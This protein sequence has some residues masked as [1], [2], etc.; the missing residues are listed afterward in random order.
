MSINGSGPLPSEGSKL[1]VMKQKLEYYKQIIDSRLDS[2]VPEA[3][4]LEESMRYS[5]LAG[6]KRI[7][8]VLTLEFARLCGGRVEDALDAACAVEM[9]HAYSLIHDD[10]PCMDN[11]ELRRGRPTNHIVYGEWLALLAGDALQ[12]E[13]FLCLLRSGLPAERK[14]GAAELLARAAGR[15]GM[16]GGQY[17]DLDSESKTLTEAQLY[18]LHGKKTGAVIAAACMMGAV[19]A[20]AGAEQ[21]KAAEDYG[22][23][24]GLAFQIRDDILDIESS[25]EVMGKPAGSDRKNQ[26]STF[27]FMYGLEKCKGLVAEYSEKALRILIDNFDDPGFLFW[28]TKEL[29][30]RKS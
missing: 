12:A 1:I 11:D 23:A 5:L 24:L 16:C 21:V 27:A 29:I 30:N 26:K 22:K 15:E 28:L 17:L 7:R 14:A 10:L 6:G 25:S 18:E 9:L 2:L 20:G 13:A 4:R 19:C 3:G 8:P